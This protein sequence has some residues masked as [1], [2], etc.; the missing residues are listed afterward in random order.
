MP[1]QG[2]EL[3]RVLPEPAVAGNRDHLPPGIRAGI[4]D[5]CPR[6]HRRGE[7]EADRAQVA[8]HE[9][10]LPID[11]EVPAERVRVV[12]DVDTDHRIVGDMASESVE[13]RRRADSRATVVGDARALLG[14]PDLPP[15]GD[16]GTLVDHRDHLWK[17]RRDRR[18]GHTDITQHGHV[19]GV[20]AAERHRIVVDLDRRLVGRDAGVVR[21]RRTPDDEQ[22]G[23][24]HQITRNRCA[25]ATEHTRTEAMVV[26]D[27][28]L[29]LERR[30]H[31]R[32]APLGERGDRLHVVPRAVT[33]DEHGPLGVREMID[34]LEQRTCGRRDA[35]IAVP[36][37]R[38]AGP[39]RG[40]R[41]LQL[42]GEHEVGDPAPDD[43]LL[44]GDR[45]QLGVIGVGV[46]RLAIRRDVGERPLEVE[47]LERSTP[48]DAR[49]HLTGDRQ[50]GRP[51]DPCV[52]QPGQEVR[53]PR[54]G[55]REARRRLAGQ[56]AVGADRECGGTLVADGHIPQ[57]S[58]LL[59]G[60]HRIRESEVRVTDHAEDNPHP[61]VGHRLDQH[62]RHRALTLLL[63]G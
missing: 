53:A 21:E 45:H 47:I 19:D 56:L 42:V 24:V 23:L 38:T 5:G 50:R 41:G 27:L 20:E 40:R 58:A 14:A 49:R 55:D 52:V 35:V 48:L 36:P 59:G 57:I 11:F 46:D 29:G 33:D 13:Q 12:A 4:G 15:L 25:A 17:R 7:R 18:R 22:V 63:W 51:I 62:V 26:G 1:D 54:P 28:P 31:G 44:A 32:T 34:R 30:E 60:S 3:H 61:P 8:R 2:G 16:I 6:A 9:H 43:R 10:R 39:L 37:L